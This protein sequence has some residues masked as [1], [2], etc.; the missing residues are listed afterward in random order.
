M[1]LDCR[2][3]SSKNTG[4][5]WWLLLIKGLG[6]SHATLSGSYFLVELRRTRGGVDIV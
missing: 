1:R 5:H 6:S 3:R 2:R 4:I